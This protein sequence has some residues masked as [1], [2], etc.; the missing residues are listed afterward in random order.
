MVYLGVINPRGEDN[1]KI[2]VY[3][4]R[5][6]VK[7]LSGN[8]RRIPMHINHMTTREDGTSVTPSGMILQSFEQPETGELWSYFTL[9]PGQQHGNLARRLTGEDGVVPEDQRLTGL[10]MGFKILYKDGLPI[11]HKVHEVSL[12]YDPCHPRCHIKACFPLEDFVQKKG[13]SDEDHIKS[14]VE[15]INKT[16]TEMF[17]LP[18]PKK[19]PDRPEDATDVLSGFN[20]VET[21]ASSSSAMDITP[22]EPA[23][24]AV[25]IDLIKNASN[26]VATLSG[27]EAAQSQPAD[28]P[29]LDIKVPQL[30]L[31]KRIAPMAEYKPRPP[32]VGYTEEQIKEWQQD[33]EQIRL[34]FE[35]NQQLIQEKKREQASKHQAALQVILPTLLA[36]DQ[37]Y[38]VNSLE[39]IYANTDH[40]RE[41]K[42]KA[43]VGLITT[44]AGTV[45]KFQK[46][47]KDVNRLQKELTEQLEKHKVEREQWNKQF[48]QFQEAKKPLF[49]STQPAAQPVAPVQP[50]STLWNQELTGASK[51]I[52]NQLMAPV[53]GAAKSEARPEH[54]V[55]WAKRNA[56]LFS[57]VA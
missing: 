43:L 26:L 15:K 55:M 13:Q 57:E 20:L 47:M 41:D 1:D 46:A 33:Q 4:T 25:A 19:I 56:R 27:G 54:V 35:Q 44:G 3:L 2:S 12:C 28:E 21:G 6:Q 45:Q 50:Q 18:E 53:G 24:P 42:A 52:F 17:K 36:Q 14:L 37:G 16:K 22:S 11:A 29:V 48:Q 32:P 39:E 7:T 40:F 9:F 8:M 31:Q 30:D 51:T 38:D 34:M 49:N 23:P 5:D 10:S